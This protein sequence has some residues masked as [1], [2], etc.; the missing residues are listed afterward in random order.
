MAAAA[1]DDFAAVGCLHSLAESM[2]GFAAALA[3]LVCA[4]HDVYLKVL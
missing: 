2:D 3:W 1:I 4:F